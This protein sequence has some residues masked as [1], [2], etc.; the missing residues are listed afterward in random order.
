MQYDSINLLAKVQKLEPLISENAY[1]TEAGKR[2]PN[3]IVK[4]FR[5]EN[6]FHTWIPKSLGGWELSPMEG[7]LAMEE[8]AAVDSASAWMFQMCNAVSLLA[9]WF[10]DEGISH[11]FENGIPIFGDSFAPPMKLTR[12]NSGFSINGRSAFVS[13]SQSI[14]WFIGL[15]EVHD[16]HGYPELDEN[17]HPLSYVFCVPN[18]AFE[19]VENWNTIGMRGTGSHD[20][21]IEGVSIPSCL[22]APLEPLQKSKN[23]AYE[24]PMGT[25]AIWMGMASM[26]AL[27]LGIA[28]SAYN[29]FIT[30][31]ENKTPSYF[32]TK[33]GEGALTQYRLGEIYSHL[34]AARAFLYDT[35]ERNWDR[36]CGGNQVTNEERRDMGAACAFTTQAVNHMMKLIAESS[37]TSVVREASPLTRKFRDLHTLQQHVYTARNRYQDIGAL[38]LG[39]APPFGLFEF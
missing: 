31:C 25:L 14:D 11:I 33:V 5:E 4:A 16:K 36:R 18:S 27:T 28:K 29:D 17:D 3:S 15:G 9:A 38:C 34:N 37:G 6:M 2:V 13:N 12:T 26:S 21:K 39:M 8:M 10:N 30:L 32:D 7:C 20:V 24:T 22:A 23:A 1:A 35:L 19:V